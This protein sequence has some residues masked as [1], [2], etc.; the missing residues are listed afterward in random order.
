MARVR[1]GVSPRGAAALNDS[2][3]K[4][5]AARRC[6]PQVLAM[7]RFWS[8]RRSTRSVVTKNETAKM[9]GLI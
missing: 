8:W 6:Q 9:G 2:V 5:D 7:K 4:G 1:R 3:C